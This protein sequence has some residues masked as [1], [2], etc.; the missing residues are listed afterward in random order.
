MEILMKVIQI[1][2]KNQILLQDSNKNFCQLVVFQYISRAKD[3]KISN[4][5]KGIKTL[6]NINKNNRNSIEKA[7]METKF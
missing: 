6:S 4:N 3:E 2:F 5:L 1:I 7:H